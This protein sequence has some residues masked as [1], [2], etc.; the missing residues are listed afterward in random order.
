MENIQPEQST[1]TIVE[2]PNQEQPQTNDNVQ[3]EE[4]SPPKQEELIL[5]KFKSVEDLTNAYKNMESQYGQNS[6]ELGEL[7]KKAQ[8]FEALQ[9]YN[10]E[11]GTKYS[12]AKEYLDKILPQYS[13]EEYFGNTEFIQLYQEAFNAFGPELDTDKFISLLDGYVSA[14]VNLLEKAK[15]AKLETEKAK[16]Q[17]QFSSSDTQKTQAPIPNLATISQKDLQEYVAKYI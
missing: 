13:T 2:L 12:T 8:D 5:G 7:R 9:K 14:R 17:M 1:T 6:K 4:T 10:E 11:Q 16:S 3:L 15:S